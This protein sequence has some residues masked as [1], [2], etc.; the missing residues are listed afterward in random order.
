MKL[1]VLVV[2]GIAC[3]AEARAACEDIIALSK[4]SRVIVRSAD[5]VSSYARQFC[6]D[7]K[8][9][10]SNGTNVSASASYKFFEG[11]ASFGQTSVEEV[12]SKVC[13]AGATGN[14]KNNVYQEYVNTIAP[15][16]YASYNACVVANTGENAIDI[17]VA[18]KQATAL[19]ISTSLNSDSGTANQIV[20]FSSSPEVTCDWQNVSANASKQP[21]S[22]RGQ[23]RSALLKCTRT[24]FAIR[25][26]VVVYATS[27]PNVRL[28][29]DWSEFTPSGDS[30]DT[31]KDLSE[32]LS[33]LSSSTAATA[34]ALK[35]DLAK[36]NG[37]LRRVDTRVDTNARVAKYVLAKDESSCPPNSTVVSN[38]QLISAS[39]APD[40][41]VQSSGFKWSS[42]VMVAGFPTFNPT[43]CML[44]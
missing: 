16:A 21:I 29:V 2:L 11:D 25:S 37:D 15:N 18:A 20:A 14:A 36:T 34:D 19:A 17:S 28:A 35:A 24:N 33:R 8:A 6:S 4:Q 3:L 7:Y 12:A 31:L 38:V 40:P 9:Y 30:K 22:L 5:E 32:T 26:S 10:K 43:L 41:R 23:R 39:V 1:A 42:G 27:R 13:E 44:P